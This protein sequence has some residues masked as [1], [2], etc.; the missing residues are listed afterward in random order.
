MMSGNKKQ[1]EFIDSYDPV[2]DNIWRYCL[3]MTRNRDLAKDLL[4]ETLLVAYSNFG[5]MRDQKSFLA[6]LFT[7]ASRTFYRMKNRKKDI[8]FVQMDFDE[9]FDHGLP[10]D[11]ASDIALLLDN[12]DRLKPEI[13]E[14]LILFY[15]EGM[16]RKEVA[17]IQ[18]I[19]DDT[20]KS[21]L[22]RGRKELEI[23]MGV[24]D[25]S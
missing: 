4:Q 18:R 24:P 1:E 9:L 21:R 15:I 23:L 2:K 14:A 3:Y 11:T 13:K 10:P 7:I 19:S 6:Y 8:V 12:M 25:E 5:K 17:A 20:V 22:F 16:T